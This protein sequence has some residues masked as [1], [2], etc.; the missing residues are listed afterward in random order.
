MSDDCQAAII[1]T[2]RGDQI[3]MSLT[4]TDA[5]RGTIMAQLVAALADLCKE[6]I[7]QKAAE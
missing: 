7:L 4:M 6:E 5:A 2:Q 1:F 3:T